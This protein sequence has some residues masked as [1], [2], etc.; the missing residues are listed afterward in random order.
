MQNANQVTD[1][2]NILTLSMLAASLVAAADNI[3]GHVVDAAN[4]D[5]V[6]YATVTITDEHNR[7]HTTVSDISGNF[8]FHGVASGRY[9]VS[10]SYLGYHTLTQTYTSRNGET[11]TLTLRLKQDNRMLN[12]VV[13]TAHESQGI[14][15]SSVI[16]R[17][18][19][20]HLQPSSFTDLLSLLPGGTTQLPDLTNANSIKL[21]Q[22]GS[23]G[24]NY[25]ISSMGTVFVADG[26]PM[27]SNAN[28]QTVKQASSSSASDPDAGRNHTTSGVDMRSIPTDNIESVEVIRGIA[29]VEYGDMTSGVVLIKRKLKATPLEARFKA[30]SYSKLLYAGKGMQF[31]SFV[32]NL[33]MDYLDAKADPRNPMNN[34]KRLTA[35]A[36]M[37]DTWQLGT[38]RLRWRS[39]TDY[40]GSFDDE[41]H[42]PEI[43]KQKDDTYKSTYNRLSMSHSVL[44][45]SGSESFFKSVSLDVAAAYEWSRI[46]QQKGI[47]LSRDIAASTSLEEG[48]HDGT[49]LPYHYVS[50]VTVDGRPLNVYA[51]LKAQFALRSGRL[52]QSITAGMEWKMDKNYGRGQEYDP[53][54][55]VSPGTPYR[56]RIYSS[57]PA[58]HQLSF[59]VQDN[60]SMPVGGNLLSAQIGLRGSSMANLAREYAMS[61]KV[62][63]DPRFNLQWRFPEISIAGMP[64]TIDLNGGWGRQ[65]KFPTLLQIYPD[66]VYTD[67]IELNYYNQ[68]ADLR[69]LHLR[70]YID[71]PTNYRLAPARNDKWEVRLGAQWDGNTAS[72]TYFRERMDDGFRTSVKVR[73]YSY[74]DYDESAIDG[75]SLSAPPSLSGLPYA[76]KR[77]LGTYTTTTNGSRLIKEGIEWQVATKRFEML[78]TRLTVNGAWFRTTYTNSEPMFR[79]NTTAV[80]DGTPVNSL[81]I[82]YYENTAGTVREQ[83]NTN[84]MA[85][86]YIP[87]LAL[88]FS[89]TAECMWFTSSKSI[90]TSGVP[91]KYIDSNG[92]IHDFT[93][94]SRQDVYLQWLVNKYNDSAWLRQKVPFYMFMNLK[95]TKDFGRWMK[96]A[97][98]VNRMIDYMPDY[99]TNSGMKVRRTSK[100][101]FGMEMN[102]NI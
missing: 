26:I 36:R 39:N 57:I 55:P 12:E 51:K 30:D 86:T 10:V 66:L 31:G 96:I 15:T 87:R 82:G 77:Q 32:M 4:N 91:L 50:N 56:P 85:D 43:L 6:P 63:P 20:E 62:Y 23:G 27:N 47:S 25:D 80:V 94:E 22:A 2:R 84:F 93:E 88:S 3:C 97:L 64:M 46:E 9:T 29:P 99:T 38:A 52:A 89:L 102:F 8:T 61:G 53:A 100:P 83:L 75:S 54:L 79:S 73:P 65:S 18:A 33:G 42:D 44:L 95:V 59:F 81:Y 98:F 34:Y 70:T 78:K 76:E 67:L 19:I 41:K 11:A 35:S 28:M 13:V 17:K 71:N 40:T 90:R 37:Q 74:R 68:N 5:A 48:E 45:T 101:Y 69:R 92:D 1:K 72:V 21:R 14:T 24:S 49:Y 60:L 58:M 16:D 7:K